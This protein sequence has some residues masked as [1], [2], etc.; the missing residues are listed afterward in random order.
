MKKITL[1]I[2]ILF[3]ISLNG[4]YIVRFAVKNVGE[5]ITSQPEKIENKIKKPLS[6]SVKLSALWIG[7]S[8]VLL[9]VYDKVIMTDPFLNYRISGMFM[10]KKEPGMDFSDLNKLNIVL[11]SHSHPDHMNF[12]SLGMI[13]DKFPGCNLVFPQGDENYLPNFNLNFV[14]VKTNFYRDKKYTGESVEVDGIKITPVYA[15]HQGGRYG[16]DTYSWIEQGATGY[17]IQYKGITIY[18]AGDTGYDDVA[19]K[20][21]G[22]NFKID[23]ALIPIG[24][25][26][27][28]ES[29]GMWYHT[30]TIEALELF[31]DIKASYMIPI[32]FGAIQYS[33]DANYPVEVLKKLIQDPESEY[34][35]ISDKL[36][37]L[38]EGEQIVWKDRGNITLEHYEAI[39]K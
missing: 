39:I 18:F 33:K 30:S 34:N 14:M 35:L 29:R 10:R 11:I 7:H 12:T 21:I 31:K 6:D 8:T 26:R 36:V 38:K 3:L 28:C 20:K 19:F 15:L 22:E 25:C 27:E 1:F 13:E 9:Q 32:H 16:I 37:I 24:P 2:I 5:S 4:C 23:L 17:I